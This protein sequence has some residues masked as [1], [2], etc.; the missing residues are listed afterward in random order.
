MIDHESQSARTLLAIAERRAGVDVRR[1]RLA[2]HDL[3]M[4]ARLRRRF[5]DTLTRHQLTDLQFAIL[6]VLLEIEPEPI[7]MAVLARQTGASRSAVTDA[8]DDLETLQ[9]AKRTRDCSDRRV[10]PVRITAAGRERIDQAINDY[11]HIASLR[12]R[13]HGV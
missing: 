12:E 7:P 10:I 3:S 6:V 5:Q 11:L 13:P 2:F 8:L 4:A 1:C 9:L